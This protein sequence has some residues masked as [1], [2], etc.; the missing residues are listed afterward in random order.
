MVT[1]VGDCQIYNTYI[2]HIFTIRYNSTF[3]YRYS[4]D[5][6]ESAACSE[7]LFRKLQLARAVLI[8]TMASHQRFVICL[9]YSFDGNRMRHALAA[10]SGRSP[11]AV[12]L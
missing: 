1:R 11:P 10:C 5:G 4:N 2:M 9:I 8:H 3:G 6:T 7:M 12:H